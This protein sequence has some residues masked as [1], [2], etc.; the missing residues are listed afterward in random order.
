SIDRATRRRVLPVSF[1]ARIAFVRRPLG[2]AAAQRVAARALL[3][4]DLACAAHWLAAP[5]V[6]D[7]SDLRSAAADPGYAVQSFELTGG[8]ADE[9]V[10]AGLFNGRLTCGGQATVWP[11]GPPELE[12]VIDRLTVYSSAVP[13]TLGAQPPQVPAG[14]TARL[15]I[16][17]ATAGRAL[18]LS[19]ASDLPPAQRGTIVSGQPGAVGEGGDCRL[20][21]VLGA[22]TLAE[23][24]APQAADLGA[25][26]QEVVN[27]HLAT[28]D[29]RRGLFLGALVVRLLA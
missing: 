15:V 20:H 21:P 26:R 5:T 27:V 16:R 19:V 13:L 29:G 23:Y 28:P 24:H 11:P 4:D 2:D 22:E 18:A 25:L 3:L 7:G 1:S 12:G 17:G 8:G 9:D 14:G 6:R 10:A